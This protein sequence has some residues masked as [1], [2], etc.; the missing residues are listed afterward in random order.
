MPINY[1]EV[2]PKKIFK[3]SK[4]H[5][6]L[7]ISFGVFLSLVLVILG[8]AAYTYPKIK[9]LTEGVNK[10]TSEVETLQKAIKKQDVVKAKNSLN[11]VETN[12]N[13]T[14]KDLSSLKFIKL[15]PLVN[16]YYNDATHI[17]E[18]GIYATSAGEIVADS[19]LPFGDILG[20][21]GTSS[22]LKAEKKVEVLVTEVFPKISA[23]TDDLED[24]LNK[25]KDE[26][27]E[28]NVN[29][30]PRLLTIKGVN[31]RKNLDD[32][33]Y[34]LDKSEE[35][36][37]IIK[38][39]VEALP[40]VLGYKKEKTYLL[41][42]QNDGELRATGGFIT[43]Y[44][45]LNIKDGKLLD[46]KSENILELDKS[47][48]PIEDPPEVYRKYFGQNFFPIRDSNVS[49]DFKYSA[50]KFL[51]FY[52]TIPNQP[53]VDGIIAI[54]TSLVPEFLRITGPVTL[55]KYNETFSAEPHPEYGIS[56]AVYK[57]ELYAQ[58][59]LRG[60]TK[61]K[62]PIGDLM[63]KVLDKLFNAK[64]DQFPDIFDV[65]L[66]SLESK[67][68]Q[69]YFRDQ[70]AQISSE[71]LGFGGRIKDF[72]GDYLH[73]NNSNVAGLKGNF[74]T[75]FTIEQDIVV[76]GDGT[77]VKKVTNNIN[78]TFR[79]DGWLNSVY[80]NWLRVYVPKGSKLVEK[81]VGTDFE[82][83][84]ELDKT[85]WSS[86]TRTPPFNTTSS[87]FTYQLPFKV[88]KGETYKMLI[89]KQGGSIPRMKIKI[90]GKKLFEFDL[91]KDTEI[92]FKV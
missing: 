72:K 64:S 55:E 43:A 32:A 40:S 75:K 38:D 3:L 25:I 28:V 51:S 46:I 21:K 18:A 87:S 29:R 45:F 88:K 71:E 47:F 84:K 80:Q 54:D 5:L 89:Q 50:E 92:K 68:I 39:V 49:P 36:L 66:K 48:V 14:K 41:W 78:N 11:K 6:W 24:L 74:F 31:V 27:D 69:F 81:E 20:L 33:K 44:G 62:G 13:A 56:D 37:P 83:K 76:K 86:F 52:R 4:K 63:Q 61:R 9:V 16:S 85:V 10:T 26:M 12:L 77:V 59:I 42:F 19:I 15:I 23:R 57:L 70:K 91:L 67:N 34:A 82:E 60:S 30:Y 53:Q 79:Y 90:N 22:N 73:V 8:T 7:K 65:V 35:Y 2:E 58:R 17:V 1:V